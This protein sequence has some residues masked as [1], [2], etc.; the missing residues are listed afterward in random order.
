MKDVMRNGVSSTAS[1]PSYEPSLTN[2]TK[3]HI[4]FGQNSCHPLNNSIS[5]IK[6]LNNSLTKTDL[7]Q[8]RWFLILLIC[9]ATIAAFNL[10]ITFWII[11]VL[12]LTDVSLGSMSIR[13][14][15]YLL[16][17]QMTPK[18]FMICCNHSTIS[19]CSWL[20]DRITN[21]NNLLF[22]NKNPASHILHYALAKIPRSTICRS[23]H[24]KNNKFF[25]EFS[26]HMNC[27]CNTR[28]ELWNNKKYIHCIRLEYIKP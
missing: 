25:W 23:L 11:N 10:S 1:H 7:C 17:S 4:M 2:P 15:Y 27:K 22:S 28:T 9:L 8:K 14:I 13:Q 18:L 21:A 24:S 12:K 6:N 19:M 16:P 20:I 3:K 5:N 26:K